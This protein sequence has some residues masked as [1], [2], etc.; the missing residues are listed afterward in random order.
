MSH[1]SDSMR[2]R[3]R[4]PLPGQTCVF[5]HG[6]WEARAANGEHVSH[7]KRDALLFDRVYAP[8]VDGANPPDIPIEVSFGLDMIEGRLREFDASNAQMIAQ[9]FAGYSPEEINQ[10]LGIP[11]SERDPL[12]YDHELVEEYSQVGIMGEW[13]YASTGAYLRRFSK[14]E[15]IAYEGALK[16]IPLVKAATAPWDQILAFRG[17]ADAV[18]KYRD[19]RLWLRSGLKAESPQHA[20]DIIGQMIDDYRWAIKRHGLQT[21]VGVFRTVFDWKESKL[22]LAATGLAAVTGGPIGAAIAGGLSVALQIG[23]WLT[24][25]R[26]DA[27]D[28]GRGPNREVAILYDIQ[29]QFGS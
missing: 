14:G 19:F 10:G 2:W 26:L 24:E 22:T 12:G 20:A 16:N 5:S 23:A 29:E 7:W 18:R 13:T 3:D 11:D 15:N 1:S 8:Y 27:K 17:D 28:I 4:R 25:R 9:A 21:S 6:Y